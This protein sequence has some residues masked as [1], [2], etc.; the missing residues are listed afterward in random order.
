MAKNNARKKERPNIW[1]QE[2]DPG[3]R[4]A[5]CSG[6]PRQQWEMK[7]RRVNFGFDYDFALNHN[8]LEDVI[9]VMMCILPR[10]F[11]AWATS[12]WLSPLELPVTP[13]HSKYEQELLFPRIKTIVDEIRWHNVVAALHRGPKS[14]VEKGRAGVELILELLPGVNSRVLPGVNRFSS[15]AWS[16]PILESLP[17]PNP[18]LISDYP[19]RCQM[20]I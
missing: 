11:T 17:Q 3:V 14:T 5:A 2:Q 1:L 9:S 12:V 19:I 15:Y 20:P 18:S 10:W 7:D 16:R 8:I 4:F 13:W 6:L